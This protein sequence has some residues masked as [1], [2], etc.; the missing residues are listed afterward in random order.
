[1]HHPLLHL[2]VQWMQSIQQ[3]G[4]VGWFLFIGLY[5][6]ACV[7]FIPGSVLTL[8]AGAIYGWWG[9]LALVLAG[10]GLGS[11]LCL[12]ITRYLFRDWVA[13]RVRRNRKAQ[14]IEKAV[15]ED[16]WKIVLLTRMSPI[17]PFSLINYS[18]GLTRISTLQFLIATELGAIP[19]TCL[20]VYLGH[21]IGNLQQIRVDMHG[22]E[23]LRWL[24]YLLGLILTVGATVYVSVLASRALK[25]HMP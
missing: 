18:L 24:A 7:A 15:E 1:M 5:A 21:L 22:H 20:Y 16:G 25:K 13:A 3:A 11:V 4:W 9:G 14:A 12:L 19:S 8:G 17:M 23:A 6:F 10:N 2:L